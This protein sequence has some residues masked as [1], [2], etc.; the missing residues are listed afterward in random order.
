MR[1]TKEILTDLGSVYLSQVMLHLDSMNLCQYLGYNGLKRLHRC[2]IKEFNDYLV[3]LENKAIDY[4]GIVI[5]NIKSDESYKPSSIMN[6][7]SSILEKL[8]ETL[9]KLS[10]LNNE[11]FEL[12]GV[13][14]PDCKC[15]INNTFKVMEKYRRIIKRYDEI[16]NHATAIHDLHT[17]DDRLHD[18]IENSTKEK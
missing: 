6:H 7:A 16:V 18:K 5:H 4:W 10:E 9:K 15:A 11:F 8:E 3:Y 2:K 14:A 17:W 13:F 12:H 1:T